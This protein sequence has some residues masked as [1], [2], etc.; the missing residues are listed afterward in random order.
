MDTKIENK[1]RT[2]S[3]DLAYKKM[4]KIKEESTPQSNDIEKCQDQEEITRLISCDI[5][6]DVCKRGVVVK[7]CNRYTQTESLLINIRFYN[8]H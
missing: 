6:L 5:C 2:L 7:C 3:D 8:I 1:K 4:C